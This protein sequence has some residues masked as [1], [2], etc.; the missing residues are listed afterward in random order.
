MLNLLN[1][2]GI[3]LFPCIIPY[4]LAPLLSPLALS[5]APSRPSRYGESGAHKMTN[6]MIDHI[7]VAAL[8]E[9]RRMRNEE[10]CINNEE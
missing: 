3:F 2:C 7:D 1:I 8:D 10:G 9:V 4:A 5:L 6:H